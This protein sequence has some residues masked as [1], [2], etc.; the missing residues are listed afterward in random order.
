MRSLAFLRLNPKDLASGLLMMVIGLLVMWEAAGYRLGSASQMGAGYYPMLLGVALVLL[1]IGILAVSR[2]S[3]TAKD[4]SAQ[5]N[6]SQRIE[7][8]ALRSTLL[9]PL[10][11]AL[12]AAL[13]EPAGLIPA[14][15][16]L[17]IVSSLAAPSFSVV[18]L[19]GLCVGVPVLV[20]LIF[21]VGLGLPFTLVGG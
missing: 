9:V 17:V 4:D 13:L 2:C 15:V 8:G 16:V 11:I 19:I 12:F 1:G 3:T 20:V 18:R 21:V 5:R 14:C 7:R 6:P 10:S